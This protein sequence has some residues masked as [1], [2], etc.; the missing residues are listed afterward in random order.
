VPPGEAYVKAKLCGAYK[1]EHRYR[2]YTSGRVF[3]GLCSEVYSIPVRETRKVYSVEPEKNESTDTSISFSGVDGQPINADI[4]ISYLVGPNSDEIIKMVRTYGGNIESIIDGHVRDATQDAL[5]TCASEHDMTARDIAGKKKT[6]LFSCAHEKVRKKFSPNGLQISSLVL[7]NQLRLSEP[8]RIAMEAAETATRNIE[9]AHQELDYA[10]AE[11]EKKKVQ[12]LTDGQALMIR[13]TA[14][15]EANKLV[16][17]SLTINI[18][19]AKELSVAELQIGK[20]NGQLPTTV[21][22][23]KI[24]MM[25]ELPR[26]RHPLP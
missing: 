10:T 12:A 23:D 3:M 4:A 26:I 11:G 21:M 6:L 5:N 1:E 19:R 9:R 13:A 24:P 7:A 17:P 8:I 16:A 25:M 14:E 22:N 2:V 15:A 20:W 18:L